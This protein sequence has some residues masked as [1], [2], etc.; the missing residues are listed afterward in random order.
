[1]KEILGEDYDPLH[2]LTGRD[3]EGKFTFL[4]NVDVPKNH[5]SLAYLVHAYGVSQT[6][7]K[8]LRQRGGESIP[9]QIPHNKGLSVVTDKEY[10]TTV[11]T[12][13]YFF[14]Q[15][16]MKKW[17][18]KNPHVSGQRKQTRRTWLRKQWDLAKEK[19][20]DFGP[21]YE[22]RSRDHLERHKGAKTDLVE[23]LNRNGRRSYTSLG[24][25]MNNWCSAKTIERF[26]KSHPDYLT[27]S[28]NV[29][30]LLSEGNR[31]KQVAF[32]KHVQDRWGLGKGKKILWTMRSFALPMIITLTYALYVVLDLKSF[33]VPI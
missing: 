2:V 29:R 28:Q 11:Y 17:L 26:L 33:H 4:K 32:S 31:L 6:T 30:P 9:K 8:R 20:P 27:Y 10:A 22:K 12:A 15:S 3:D 14:V 23:I 24:K 16:Q 1:M 18:S 13:R 7:F 25:A 5:P 21:A 19:D